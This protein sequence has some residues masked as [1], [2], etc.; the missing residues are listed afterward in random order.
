MQKLLKLASKN[1]LKLIKRFEI[2]KNNSKNY[3]EL[4]NKLKTDTTYI[5]LKKQV[6]DN[7]QDIYRTVAK[8][9]KLK[10]IPIYL[11]DKYKI[12]LNGVTAFKRFTGTPQSITIFYQTATEFI[13]FDEKPDGK[14]RARDFESIIDTLIHEITHVLDLK[15]R[16]IS[17]HDLYFY[18]NMIK[19]KKVFGK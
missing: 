7:L 10:G 12:R 17:I 2:L 18:N 19:V 4:R 6:R 15:Q 11:S 14:L 1:Y 3:G 5:E 13:K 16:K 9:F 8:K